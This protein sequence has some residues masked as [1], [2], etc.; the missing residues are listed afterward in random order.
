MTTLRVHPRCANTH[1]C[2]GPTLGRWCNTGV[3]LKSNCQV[4]PLGSTTYHL[5]NYFNIHVFPSLW[6]RWPLPLS[7]FQVSSC[8]EFQKPN[9][10]ATEPGNAE[11]WILDFKTTWR[12]NVML[13]GATSVEFLKLWPCGFKIKYT[14]AFKTLHTVTNKPYVNEVTLTGQNPP[15]K[16][17]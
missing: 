13:F 2:L 4:E 14:A 7:H 15:L 10:T 12:G 9:Q 6:R 17:C 3:N 8:S 16:C 11:L 5:H 1:S